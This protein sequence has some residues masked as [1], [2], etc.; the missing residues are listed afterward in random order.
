MDTSSKVCV[1]GGGGGVNFVRVLGENFIF[2][3]QIVAISVAMLLLSWQLQTNLWV[4]E[5]SVCQQSASVYDF[6]KNH[7]SPNLG[8]GS[9]TNNPLPPPPTPHTHTHTHPIN[10]S[11]QQHYQA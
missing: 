6:H 2:I 7:K 1:C 8:E 4:A 9:E 3:A 10:W 11:Q 5:S